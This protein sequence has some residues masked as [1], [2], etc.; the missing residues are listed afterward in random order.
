[1]LSFNTKEEEGS[2]RLLGQGVVKD[3]IHRPNN[4]YAYGHRGRDLAYSADLFYFPE[5]K[6]TMVLIVNYGTDGDSKLRPAFYD[7]RKAV[8]DSMMQ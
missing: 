6:Q 3:F 2:D 8:V 1:M 4:E 5:Q 7:L